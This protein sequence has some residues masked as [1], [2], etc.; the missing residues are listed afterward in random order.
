MP[1]TCLAGQPM[2]MSMMS[3]P[4][5]CRDARAFGHPVRLAAGELHDVEPQPLAVEPPLLLALRPSTSASL[6]I[7][8]ET[9]TPAPRLAAR[10]RNGASV[11]P[12]MGARNTRFGS[13]TGPTASGLAKSPAIGGMVRDSMHTI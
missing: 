5:A 4:A 10:R 1:V 8:S 13:V 11:M 9:T 2:L 6:A 7:I 12:D 3:A